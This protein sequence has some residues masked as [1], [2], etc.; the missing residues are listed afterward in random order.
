[1]GSGQF[2][3]EKVLRSKKQPEKIEQV[4]STIQVVFAQANKN[5]TPSKGEKKLNAPE[6]CPKSVRGLGRFVVNIS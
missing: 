2:P 5:H 1:M 4:L 6:N 3:N